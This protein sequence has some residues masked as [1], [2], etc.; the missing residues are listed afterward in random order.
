MCYYKVISNSLWLNRIDWFISYLTYQQ[1]LTLTTTPWNTLHSWFLEHS[2]ILILLNI[3]F[4]DFIFAASHPLFPPLVFL[5][6]LSILHSSWRF[7]LKDRLGF[8]LFCGLFPIHFMSVLYFLL[9][10]LSMPC[11]LSSFF[12]EKPRPLIFFF[13]TTLTIFRFTV[14]WHKIHSHSYAVITAIHL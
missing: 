10:V 12:K 8:N 1:H 9:F 14:Q 4:P 13:F 11:T 2:T 6:S 5:E 7:S 3:F